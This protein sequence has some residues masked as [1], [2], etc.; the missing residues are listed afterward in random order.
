MCA[1]I[2]YDCVC[3]SVMRV[4]HG[5]RVCTHDLCVRSA[6]LCVHDLAGGG[7]YTEEAGGDGKVRLALCLYIRD[8]WF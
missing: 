5:L 3:V 4:Y 6:C 8:L 7:G 1:T 2:V